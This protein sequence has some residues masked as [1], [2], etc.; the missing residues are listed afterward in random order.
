MHPVSSYE[1]QRLPSG[2]LVSGA[3]VDKTPTEE[4]LFA[5]DLPIMEPDVGILPGNGRRPTAGRVAHP[6]TERRTS[7]VRVSLGLLTA[8]AFLFLNHGGG[9][10]GGGFHTFYL[11]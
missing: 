5:A 9:R 7:V 4:S 10:G 8:R 1:R 11:E 6:K 3:S 2:K